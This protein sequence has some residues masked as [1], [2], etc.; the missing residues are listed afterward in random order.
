MNYVQTTNVKIINSANL[1]GEVAQAQQFIRAKLGRAETILVDNISANDEACLKVRTVRNDAFNGI[2]FDGDD[3]YIRAADFKPTP[4]NAPRSVSLWVWLDS[5]ATGEERTL[6]RWGR[7]QNGALFHLMTKEGKLYLDFEG[8]VSQQDNF[9]DM[10]DSRWHHIALTYAGGDN[11]TL[12]VNDNLN[13]YIDGQKKNF[14]LTTSSWTGTAFATDNSSAADNLGL[15]LGANTTSSRALKGALSDFR[16][17][18]RALSADEIATLYQGRASQ[19]AIDGSDLAIHWALQSVPGDNVTI[20]DVSTAGDN[21]TA[22]NFDTSQMAFAITEEF[23]DNQVF[24]LT[25][26]DNDSRY[27]LFYNPA[28]EDCDPASG[29]GWQSVSKDIFTASN[30]GFFTLSGAQPAAVAFNFGYRDES[31]KLGAAGQEPTSQRIGLSRQFKHD[32]F[33]RPAST[34]TLK[35]AG[36]SISEAYIYIATDFDN[37]TESLAINGASKST[38]THFITYSDIPLADSKMRAR[39]SP[40]TGVMRFKMTDNSSAAVS[41]WVDAM[42]FVSYVPTA[43]SYATQKTISFGLGGLPLA[44]D[45]NSHFYRFVETSS[46]DFSAALADAKLVSNQ[47]CGYEGHMATITTSAE[48]SLLGTRFQMDNGSH[49]TAFLAAADN[50]SEGYWTWLDGPEKGQRF[51]QGNGVND[52]W[53]GNPIIDD[54]TDNGTVATRNTYWASVRIDRDPDDNTSDTLIEHH[55]D[56]LLDNVSLRFTY[57]SAGTGD[58][59]MDECDDSHRVCEPNDYDSLYGDYLMLSGSDEGHGLWHDTS[60]DRSCGSHRLFGVCGY[61]TEWRDNNSSDSKTLHQDVQIDVAKH[62]THCQTDS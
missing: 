19:P 59:D 31:D 1:Q 48:N 44:Q 37:N 10:R 20:E 32:D 7:P 38:S 12:A 2:L 3:S 42:R 35:A 9:T 4:D 56:P 39:Y 27:Q 60:A 55:I 51:W 25:D 21:G 15:M 57:W 26:T 30:D 18:D 23:T 46:S 6:A 43:T 41:D 16:I 13:V 62:R 40:K 22:S 52:R 29:S 49:V 5:Q 45:G 14:G 47:I 8:G 17:W 50:E 33:C 58:F 28:S 54:G 11:V 24:A 36:C 53:S 34:L 61:F